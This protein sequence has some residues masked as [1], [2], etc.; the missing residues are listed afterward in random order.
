MFDKTEVPDKPKTSDK[1]EKFLLSEEASDIFEVP[2][3]NANNN[4]VS[5][6]AD[7]IPNSR[8]NKHRK[9]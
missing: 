7:E 3:S 1:L 4:R 6:L 8:I 9:T 2:I 5:S